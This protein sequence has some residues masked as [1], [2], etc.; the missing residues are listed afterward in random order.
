MAKRLGHTLFM[1]NTTVLENA[2]VRYSQPVDGEQDIRFTVLEVNG[3]RCF[4]RLI[5]DRFDIEPIELGMV[6]DFVVAL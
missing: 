4:V 3:D 6:A 5:D 2:T 1:E